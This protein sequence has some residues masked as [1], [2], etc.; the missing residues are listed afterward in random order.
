MIGQVGL[1]TAVKVAAFWFGFLI[2]HFLYDWLPILPVALFSGVSEAVF[3]HA[4]IAFYVYLLVSLIEI[5]IF[6]QKH[7]Q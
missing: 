7:S 5:L 4:K 6:C 1:K 2:L 3:Q